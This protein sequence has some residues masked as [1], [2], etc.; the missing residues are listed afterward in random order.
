MKQEKQAYRPES[1]SVLGRMESR[2]TTFSPFFVEKRLRL[3][4]HTG[5]MD[6][7]Q[8][9]L[10][11][12]FTLGS[13]CDIPVWFLGTRIQT[14]DVWRCVS[15]N[16]LLFP[17]RNPA[18][19]ALFYIFYEN[20]PKKRTNCIYMELC[21]SFAARI[22]NYFSTLRHVLVTQTQN[23]DVILR[24]GTTRPL[25]VVVVL[26]TVIAPPSPD[27]PTSLMIS[28]GQVRIILLQYTYRVMFYLPVL[29]R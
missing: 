5:V 6:T 14:F 15:K 25:L 19:S 1:A 16:S 22:H 26:G 7:F 18:P 10:K 12:V 11:I 28:L 13:V 3:F 24:T 2:G 29:R 9:I 20:R 21:V 27:C 17:P 23:P 8:P 4:P